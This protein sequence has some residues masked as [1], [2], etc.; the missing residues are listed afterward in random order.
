MT[1]STFFKQKYIYFKKCHLKL[2]ISPAIL[3]LIERI[4]TGIALAIPSSNNEK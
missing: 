3:T 2:E 4:K 1:K